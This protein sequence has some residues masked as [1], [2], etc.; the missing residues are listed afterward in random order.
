[1]LRVFI[2][3]A[4]R[5]FKGNVRLLSTMSI[6]FDG[7]V[8]IVTG[9][10]GGLGRTY[11]LELAKR[12]AKVVVN[13]LGGDRHGTS[14]STSAADKVV[15]EI[16]AAGGTAV[17]NYDS[18]EFG[19]KIVKTAVDN[20]GR[21]DILINNAGILRDV[22]FANMKDIDWNLIMKVHLYGAYSCT[23]AAWPYFRKQNYGRLVFTSSNSGMYGSFGQVNYAAAKM[24]LVGMSHSLALEG[25]KYKIFSNAL[26][27]T[28]GSRMTQTVL[29]QE[30]VDI[31]KPDYVTPLVTFLASKDNTNTGGIYEAGAGWFGQVKHYRSKGLVIPNA[32]AENIRDSWSQI[33][34]QTGAVAYATSGEVTAAL[35]EALEKSKI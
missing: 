22:S 15:S 1:M 23:K 25:K 17:A 33:T 4:T 35:L 31:L 24:A 18:V 7:Q 27:P 9:A 13:D 28:A 11:A 5:P 20:Y 26:I 34:D 2:G 3:L 21:I 32:K 29:P 16:K 14:Q 30:M 10:G 12:G 6:R 8:A 19:D